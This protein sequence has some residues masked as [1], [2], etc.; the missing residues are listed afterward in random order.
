MQRRRS[1]ADET[2]VPATQEV[3]EA[4]PVRF[5]RDRLYIHV[6]YPKTVVDDAL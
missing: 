2:D 1:G 3:K 6:K 5:F 4:R